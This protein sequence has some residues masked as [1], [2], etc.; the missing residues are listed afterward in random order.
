MQCGGAQRVAGQRGERGRL[1]SL[2]AHVAEEEREALVVHR[3]HVVEVAAEPLGGGGVVVRGRLHA[4]D[5]RQ[6]V[7][8]QRVLEDGEGVLQP[9]PVR[10]GLPARLLGLPAGFLGLPACLLRLLARLL[11]GLPAAQQLLLVGA[12]V[13]GVEDGGADQQRITGAAVLDHR[14]DQHG[15]PAAAG[16]LDVQR[17]AGEFALHAQQGREVRLVV[18]LAAHGQQ[19]GE[20]D[21]AHHL[22]AVPADPLQQGG[23]DL[24][25]GA[26]HQR[27]QVAAGRRL[28]QFLGAVLQYRGERGVQGALVVRAVRVLLLPAAA[29]HRRPSRNVRI[30]ALVASG[31]DRW[32]QWPV[33]SRVTSVEPGTARWT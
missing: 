21:P 5:R 11:G 7:G 2:A 29:H 24:R 8:Q 6:D 17:D 32:G 9:G 13:P 28:V 10:L 22:L 1:G 23:V 20:P 3:E 25:D 33:A 15:H 30:A 16:P 14:G 26:V 18:Q 19:V 4:G 12:A 31:A 27:G